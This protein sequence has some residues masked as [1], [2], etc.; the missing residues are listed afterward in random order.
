MQ[1]LFASFTKK[2]HTFSISIEKLC[3]YLH[4]DS[5]IFPFVK[6]KKPFEISSKRS[7]SHLQTSLHYFSKQQ[8]KQKEEKNP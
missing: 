6:W 5:C 2:P 3:Q 7:Y 1:V 4:P 8:S